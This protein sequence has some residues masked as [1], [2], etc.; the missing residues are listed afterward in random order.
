VRLV[1]H[2]CVFSRNGDFNRTYKSCLF[3]IVEWLSACISKWRADQGSGAGY[4][5][6][7]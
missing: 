6:E 2:F 3:I 1:A 5:Q 4:L 7:E